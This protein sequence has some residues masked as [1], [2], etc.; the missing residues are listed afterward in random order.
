MAG[1]GDPLFRSACRRKQRLQRRI[2]GTSA[3]LPLFT[4][5]TDDRGF[6]TVRRKVSKLASYRFAYDLRSRSRGSRLRSLNSV[7]SLRRRRKSKTSNG[8]RT[9][10]T[11]NPTDSIE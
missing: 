4:S 11:T 8:R 9:R 5:T 10:R 3:W 6:W 2:A 1:V 7:R